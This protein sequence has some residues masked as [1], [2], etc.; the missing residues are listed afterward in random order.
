M[1]IKPGGS[2]FMGSVKF[3]EAAIKTKG[4]IKEVKNLPVKYIEFRQTFLNSKQ[5]K[6]EFSLNEFTWILFGSRTNKGAF[7]C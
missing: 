5:L 1:S 2:N 4:S 3:A 7:L 6:L